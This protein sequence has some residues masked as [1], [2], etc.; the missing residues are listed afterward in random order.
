MLKSWLI[1]Q[2][3]VSEIKVYYDASL[4]YGK[5]TVPDAGLYYIGAT[6]AQLDFARFVSKLPRSNEADPAAPLSLS[7]EVRQFE[8][9]LLAAYKPPA[10][11]DSHPVFIRTSAMVKQAHELQSAGSMYGAVY[12]VL[13]PESD[14]QKHFLRQAR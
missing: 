2:T 4:E 6:L 12:R 1:G 14:S 5:N 9:Q 8:D 3:S 10:S 7:Q 13:M 11:I